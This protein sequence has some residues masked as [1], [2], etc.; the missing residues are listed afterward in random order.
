MI[1][2]FE[3]GTFRGLQQI[4]EYLFQD[5]F[6][7][8]GEVRNVDIAKGNFRFASHLYLSE[9]IPVVE[10]MPEDS[11]EAIIEKYVEMNILHPFREGNG[12]SGRIWLDCILKARLGVCVDWSLL[13]KEEYLSAMERSPVNSLELR[14]LLKSALT[15]HIDEREV[16]MKGIEHSYYYEGYEKFEMD[17]LE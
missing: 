2:T 9:S 3:V 11:F 14:V 16:F 6:L 10:R 17:R 15:D 13:G 12:R 8:P 7:S 4:H 1:D 5:V